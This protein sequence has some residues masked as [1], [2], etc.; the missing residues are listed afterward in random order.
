VG[1]V[2]INF[3]RG[4]AAGLVLAAAGTLIAVATDHPLGEVIGGLCVLFGAAGL[5]RSVR[6]ERATSIEAPNP[7]DWRIATCAFAL[8]A[9]IGVLLFCSQFAVGLRPVV[10]WSAIAAFLVGLLGLMVVLIRSL[11]LLI[12]SAPRT[13]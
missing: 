9:L 6:G 2:K 13:S 4:E 11:W 1:A 10:M 8:L 5:V 12:F 3:K 7:R